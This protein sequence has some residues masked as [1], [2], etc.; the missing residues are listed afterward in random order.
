M[1][2]ARI[3]PQKTYRFSKKDVVSSD[4]RVGVWRSSLDFK[5]NRRMYFSIRVEND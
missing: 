3:K 4:I 5:S 2:K 1:G